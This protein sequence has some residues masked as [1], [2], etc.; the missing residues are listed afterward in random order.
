MTPIHLAAIESDMDDMPGT[1]SVWCGRLDRP[2]ALAR[3][4]DTTHYAAS[5]MKIAVLAA[6]HR[7][8]ASGALD[9]DADLVLRNEFRSADPAAPPFACTCGYD[10]DP[11]VWQRLGGTGTLRWLARRMIVVSGNLATNICLTAVGRPAVAE[12]LRLV[13]ARHSV[14]AR[15]IEDYAASAR[16]VTN[17]VTAADLAA[18]LAA[19]AGGALPGREEMLTVL[20]AQERGEDLAAGLPPGTRIAHKNGWID[21]VR[22]GAGIIFPHDAPPYVLVVCTTTPLA[23]GNTGADPACRLLARV[24][25]ASWA[26]RHAL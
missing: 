20:L 26:D 14:V 21:G 12:V 1:V 25:G 22:H 13:G 23:S 19:I 3:N 4:P 7:A 5:T 17:L 2:P 8:A 24:A 6:L 16:G 11:E 9:L 15:C 10:S 18:L